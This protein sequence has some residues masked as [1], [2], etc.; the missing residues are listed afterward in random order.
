MQ[1]FRPHVTYDHSMH[2]SAAN[3]ANAG[4]WLHLLDMPAQH[5]SHRCRRFSHE[6]L[7]QACK[8]DDFF[9]LQHFHNRL[10]KVFR[11]EMSSVAIRKELSDRGS[12]TGVL[13]PPKATSLPIDSQPHI[14]RKTQPAR[15][16]PTFPI[17][18]T[19]TKLDICNRILLIRAVSALG[20]IVKCKLSASNS[21]SLDYPAM[22]AVR[23]RL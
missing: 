20:P 21:I 7:H 17:L 18:R 2:G 9:S 16:E 5:R 13:V 1:D 15:L 23:L 12:L 10:V 8:R 4:E 22:R 6:Q 11:L 14:D 19:T 3:T